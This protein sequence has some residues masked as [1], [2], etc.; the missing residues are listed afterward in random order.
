MPYH[1]RVDLH[2][3]F[4]PF[5]FIIII[6]IFVKMVSEKISRFL[7]MYCKMTFENGLVKYKCYSPQY[8]CRYVSWPTFITVN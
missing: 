8:C 6:V 1:N 3:W 4:L 5:Y 2:S 7:E